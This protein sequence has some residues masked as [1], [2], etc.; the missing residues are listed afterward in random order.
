M[1]R[2]SC[3]IGGWGQQACRMNVRLLEVRLAGAT[4]LVVATMSFAMCEPVRCRQ[5]VESHKIT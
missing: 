5:S 4:S 3:G 1:H 2:Y